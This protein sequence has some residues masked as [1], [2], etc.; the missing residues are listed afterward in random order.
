V[1]L[2]ITLKAARAGVV[3]GVM[4]A[5]ARI[6]GET[7]PLAVHGA[8]QP[9]LDVQPERADGQPAG[10]DLQVRDEPLREL[11]GAGLGRRVPD[12]AGGAGLNI[13]ARVFTRAKLKALPTRSR[14][15]LSRTIHARIDTIK[16]REDLGQGPELLL[17]QVPRPQ[18]H[19]PGNPREEGHRLHRPSGCGK[20][21]L[22]RV[23]NRMYELYPEQRAEGQIMLDGEDLLTRRRTW[24]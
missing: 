4:L 5:V 24:R 9:V 20:S 14:D 23:F 11:A 1:I 16:E 13:A 8:E 6:A 10:H 15:T 12:H 2:S 22:L 3:T 21:T 18:G 17:R 7:A 19:Q